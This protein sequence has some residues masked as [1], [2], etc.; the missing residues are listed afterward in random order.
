MQFIPRLFFAS[1]VIF[2]LIGMMWGIHMSMTTDHV[3]APA[4]GHL[5]LIGFVAMAV[6][7]TY[8]ALVPQ[9]AAGRLAIVHF[10]LA[11]LTVVVLVP[12]IVLAINGDG[13]A[14]AKIGSVLAV[15]TMLLFLITVLR[16]KAV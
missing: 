2:V 4:H 7:G 14:L 12:G 6:F 11:V 5:N 13:E 8:Y 16:H 3:L 10:A 9:A 15:L 1:A